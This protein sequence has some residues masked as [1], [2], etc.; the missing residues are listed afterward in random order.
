MKTDIRYRDDIDLLIRHFYLKV[1]NDVLLKIYFSAFD[2]EKKERF[3]RGV[4]DFWENILLFTGDY[5]GNPM[6]VHSMLHQR[7]PMNELHFKHWNE[8]FNQSVNGLFE[9]DKS[10]RMKFEAYK[11]SQIIQGKLFK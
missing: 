10:E 2:A 4:T 9:G 11:I 3:I 5:N 1:S 6:E 8:L 7:Q